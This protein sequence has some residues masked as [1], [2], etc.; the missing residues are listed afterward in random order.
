MLGSDSIFVG[1]SIVET[2]VAADPNFRSRTDKR[3][4]YLNILL[5]A[6]LFI[7]LQNN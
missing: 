5:T 4:K 1:Q 6:L 3:G 2:I 7:V